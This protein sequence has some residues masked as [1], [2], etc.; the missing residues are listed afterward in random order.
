MYKKH[1]T[2]A[3]IS[4]LVCFY[5]RHRKSIVIAV[6]EVKMTNNQWVRK[7]YQLTHWQL[8][9]GEVVPKAELVY[10][11]RGE[12]N[13]TKDNLVLLPTYYGGACHGVFPYADG[14]SP[15]ATGDYCLLVPA[16]FAN[17]ESW[18]PS[19][20]ETVQQTL[21]FPLITIADNIS[22]QKQLVHD[23]FGDGKICLICGWSMGGLQALQWAKEFPE[24]V[25]NVL[26][27]CAT[28][29]CYP[30]NAV[31]L[32][33]LKQC[34]Y[35]DEHFMLA[36]PLE[37]PIRGLTAFASVYAGWAYSQAFFRQQ[38]YK[39]LGF[40]TLEDLL[41]YWRADH[42][43]QNAHDLLALLKTWQTANI[44]GVDASEEAYCQAL[45]TIQAKT[46]MM[47][48]SMDLYFTVEDAAYDASFIPQGECRVIDSS[49][50]HCAGGP[51]RELH[52]MDS[53][54]AAI[55]DL[56]P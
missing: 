55:N 36:D 16:L 4:Q 7:S 8:Q 51:G 29:R 32:E 30:H 15:L 19:H 24:Q 45:K 3:E 14:L 52:G 18:S 44:A 9:S 41:D 28:A 27:I 43:A 56:L 54:F 10:Y 38:D 37:P 22:A 53:I 6:G 42:L 25:Q 49:F 11:Q 35:A 47:P 39:K 1:E 12:L 23:V 5:N 21:D 31:F 48:S 13:S 2:K 50:G 20:A 40:A 33:G 46:I 17:G 34:L 26:A